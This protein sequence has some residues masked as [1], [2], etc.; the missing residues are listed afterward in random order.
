MIDIFGRHNDIERIDDKTETF[1]LCLK[2]WYNMFSLF[3]LFI[4]RTLCVWVEIC[5][6]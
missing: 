4:T 2:E 1:I 5:G 3:L 6:R